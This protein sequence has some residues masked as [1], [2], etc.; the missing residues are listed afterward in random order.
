M[1]LGTID[2]LQEVL[3]SL[4]RAERREPHRTPADVR[5]AATADL[6]AEDNSV[7][8]LLAAI[9]AA[10]D[11]LAVLRDAQQVA[12][13]LANTPDC[14]E[15]GAEQS[16]EWEGSTRRLCYACWTVEELHVEH[17]PRFDV[18]LLDAGPKWLGVT[19]ALRKYWF[20]QRGDWLL[21]PSVRETAALVEGA[22]PDCKVREGVSAETAE[23]LKQQLEAVGATVE[24]R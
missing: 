14:E 9:T 2:T 20:L 16:Y 13:Q 8:D 6:V 4:R 18:I 21:V 12:E 23:H 3:Y 15:C 1:Y 10:T 5:N 22:G 17:P 19:Q 24:V 7:A 11:L